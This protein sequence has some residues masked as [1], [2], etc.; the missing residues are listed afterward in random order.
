MKTLLTLL[1]L[2]PSLSWG[3]TFK[4]GKQ[5]DEGKLSN[6]NQK[7]DYFELSFEEAPW[8]DWINT[9]VEQFC[10]SNENILIE[11][12]W[13]DDDGEWES[14]T[15]QI[16]KGENITIH[17]T[18]DNQEDKWYITEG[19]YEFPTENY[20]NDIVTI[21]NNIEGYSLKDVI[22][23]CRE[24]KTLVETIEYDTYDI[25]LHD[26]L[27]DGLENNKKI[28]AK[29]NLEIPTQD[30]CKNIK[31]YPL[32]FLIHHSGGV[33]MKDYKYIL[34]ELCIATFEPLIFQARGFFENFYDISREVQ[35]ATETAGVTDSLL[36]LDILSNKP[37]INPD[38]IGITGWS[39]GGM[40]AIEAQHKFNLQKLNTQNEFVF[41]SAI[42]PFCN[43]YEGESFTTT[44]APLFIFAGAEDIITPPALCEEYIEKMN[45]AGKNNK[46][47]I[48][49]PKTTHSYDELETFG[50]EYS[51]VTEECRLTVMENGDVIIKPNDPK[52]WFNVTENGGWFSGKGDKEVSSF[53]NE[54]CWGWGQVITHRNEKA[55]QETLNLYTENVKK[56]L[57]N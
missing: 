45:A 18:Y 20:D 56:Y 23:D 17:S 9:E 39:W 33:I 27:F 54:I 55:L 48:V 11:R 4:D 46:N 12:K 29:G 51:I 3:L 13:S 32:M 5:A 37:N 30:K 49:F 43:H 14:D 6:K 52:K 40:V 38:K 1:L 26:D 8:L 21:R 28:N 36:A 24:N 44:D 16:R 25:F 42:Y 31:K 35:W 7:L 57:S 41:H 19:F 15:Y 22:V 10:K 47:I 50:E 53:I 2:I 34:H